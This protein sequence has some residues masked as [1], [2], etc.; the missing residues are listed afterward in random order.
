MIFD[1]ETEEESVSR[2]DTETAEVDSPLE[3]EGEVIPP[4]AAD[5]AAAES[6][7][8]E[9]LVTPQLCGLLMS[10][11]GAV[12]AR[13]T[14]H[15]FWNL[16]E[17]EKQL[18]GELS[19]PLMVY[20]VRRY[21]G[22]GVGMFAATAAILAAMYGPRQLREMQEQEQAKRNRT[23]Q[24]GTSERKPPTSQAAYP[25]SSENADAARAASNGGWGVHFQ[26]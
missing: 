5:E 8:L 19:Q 4:S 26:E 10:L 16:S 20:L 6:L 9:S 3:P 1:E 7:P 14:G 18:A 11:P 2:F 25:P 15:E 24:A 21:L 22:D 17:E 23:N 12:R 13:Q